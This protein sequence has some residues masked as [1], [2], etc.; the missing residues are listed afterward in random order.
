MAEPT[1]DN[2]FIEVEPISEYSI[3]EKSTSNDLIRRAIIMQ[4]QKR[5]PNDPDGTTWYAQVMYKTKRQNEKDDS[6]MCY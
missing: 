5:N 1:E 3:G 6:V 2:H 4:I